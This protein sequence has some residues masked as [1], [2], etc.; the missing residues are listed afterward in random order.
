[1][2]DLNIFSRQRMSLAI[3]LAL[4]T[5]AGLQVAE[6]GAGWGNSADISGAEIKT[7]TYY[8]NSP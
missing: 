8:A 1:M 2:K 3:M 4:A 5:S 7:P 6:A